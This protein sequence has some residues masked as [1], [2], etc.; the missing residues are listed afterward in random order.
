MQRPKEVPLPLAPAMPVLV[1]LALAQ[2]AL[3]LTMAG[4]TAA[5]GEAAQPPHIFML[6]ADD[7]GWNDFG[8]TRGVLGNAQSEYVGPQAKTPEIDRL[9]H[10]G[11]ILH[12]SYAYRYCSPSRAAFL[13][14][15]LPYHVHE[16][17]PGINQRGCTNLNHT[18]S[19]NWRLFARPRGSY[20]KNL[21]IIDLLRK[22]KQD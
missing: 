20:K 15:R 13:T 9:A 10:G 19:T 22:Y 21:T 4:A 12:S 11:I 3:Q 17:N 2:L 7:A 18:G 8:F 1:V 14:G 5:D 16:G 6:L